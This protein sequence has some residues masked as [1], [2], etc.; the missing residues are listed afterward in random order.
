MKRLIAAL[1]LA[2]NPALAVLPVAADDSEVIEG[3]RQIENGGYELALPLL[4]SA[5][6]R[7]PNDP[8]VYVYIA[9]AERR[10]GRV[11]QAMAA[12]RAALAHEPGHA[13]ALAYQGSLF[14]AL[15]DR[16]AA[17]ANLAQLVARCATC[18]ETETLRREISPSASAPPASRPSSAPSR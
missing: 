2:A 17:E 12:Y 6:S 3:V 16:A 10:L 8:D 18:P 4:R 7:L 9:F 11:E 14:L 15:G 5:L 1:L 13:P